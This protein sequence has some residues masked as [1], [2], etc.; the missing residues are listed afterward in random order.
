MIVGIDP[1]LS[2]APFFL[3]PNR[4][5]SGEAVDLPHMLTRGA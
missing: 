5:S 3:D 1:G 4:P 2:G